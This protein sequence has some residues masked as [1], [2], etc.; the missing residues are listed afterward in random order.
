MRIIGLF[1]LDQSDHHQH[2]DQ[3]KV[4][5]IIQLLKEGNDLAMVTD[6]G[7]PAISDP[8][9][10]L[11]NAVIQEF[12]TAVHIVPIPGPSAVVTALSLAG[13]SADRF[14]FLGFPP[15]KKG[16][17]SYFDQLVHLNMTGIFYESTHRIVKALHEI[18]ERIP[19][20]A[21]V[22]CRE[23][24]KLHETIYRGTAQEVIKQLEFTSS[25]GEFVVILSST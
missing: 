4:D 13:M 19:D 22:V 15:H 25:K 18:H 7:T 16:R 12:G 11:V 17:Q 3:S 24:A 10:K 6:A 21:L 20:R 1:L 5:Q 8:G 14:V 2:N 23:L 9:G